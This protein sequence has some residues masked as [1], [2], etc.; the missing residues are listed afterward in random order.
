MRLR[1][2]MRSKSWTAQSVSL[3]QK[4]K[5]QFNDFCNFIR[6]EVWEGCG[7]RQQGRED[8]NAG[9]RNKPKAKQV[10]RRLARVPRARTTTHRNMTVW[11]RA[12]ET[13]TFKY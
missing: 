6:I 12:G 1:L 13:G 9:N 5:D 7:M 3:Q 4:I 10:R 8:L 11:Q 2:K